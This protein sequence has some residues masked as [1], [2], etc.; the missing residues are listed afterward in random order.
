MA[1]WTKVAEGETISTLLLKFGRVDPK[2][3]V[4]KASRG[5]SNGYASAAW[6]IF[7][8]YYC[9]SSENNAILGRYSKTID[10]TAYVVKIT[11]EEDGAV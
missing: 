2:G 1:L 3:I 7:V 9:W 11:A 4:E 8:I 5:G 6:I 10:G